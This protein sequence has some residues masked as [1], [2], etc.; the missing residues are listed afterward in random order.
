MRK[1]RWP[2]LLSLALLCCLGVEAA[3][4]A[5]PAAAT[6]KI[7]IYPEEGERVDQLRARGVGKVRDYGAFWLADVTPAQSAELKQQ[8]GKR[9]STCDYLDVIE[10][11]VCALNP[12]AG[13]PAI[14]PALQETLSV[15]KRL[16][17]LQLDG[18]VVPEWL[19]QIKAAGNVQI[20][21]YI[22]NNAYLVYVDQETEARLQLLRAPDGP[23]RWIGKYHPYY[24]VQPEL[25]NTQEAQ[26]S[27]RVQLVNDEDAAR[28]VEGLRRFNHGDDFRAGQGFNR[29]TAQL[30]VRPADLPAIARLPNVIWIE[31]VKAIE[32]KDEKQALILINKTNALASTPISTDRYIHFLTNTVGFSTDPNAYPIVDLADGLLSLFPSQVLPDFYELGNTNNPSRLPS[33]VKYGIT[34]PIGHGDQHA[35]QVA[36]IMSGYSLCSNIFTNR[37]IEQRTFTKT[38]LIDPFCNALDDPIIVDAPGD[39][40]LCSSTV[41]FPEIAERT[42]DVC[43]LVPEGLVVCNQFV[44]TNS[45]PDQCCFQVTLTWTYDF[46]VQ[47]NEVNQLGY[48]VRLGISPFGRF[49]NNAILGEFGESI[50]DAPDVLGLTVF[51]QAQFLARNQYLTSR[52]RIANNSWGVK[53]GDVNFDEAAGAYDELAQAYDAI[54]RDAILTGATNT[55]G[56]YPLNQEFICVFAAGNEQGL[57]DAGGFGD[58]LVFSPATAKNVISV[59]ASELPRQFPEDCGMFPTDSDNP[60]Q[61]AWFS[62]AGPTVDG[63]FKPD[64]VAP[65][66]SLLAPD[67]S[68][69]A[70][71]ANLLS[72]LCAGELQC[73]YGTSYAA[74][75]VS[76]AAQ[77]LWWYFQQRL[78]QFQPTPAMA[79]AYMCNSARHLKF[80]NPLTGTMDT[81]P[82]IGQ[83]MGILDLERMFDGFPRLIRDQTTP[84]AID[85]PLITTNPVSQQ[86]YFTRA[87]QSYEVSG[88]IFDA[89]RPFRVT[90]AWTDA[91]GDPAAFKQLQ[92][93]L[94]LD[95]RVNGQTYRGNVFAQE[96]S[97]PGGVFDDVNNI[98]SVHLPPGQTGTWS[99][100]VRAAVIAADG[101]PNVGSDI[102][103]DF[104]LVVYNAAANP[105]TTDTPIAGTNDTCSTA[106]PLTS[107]PY[108]FTGNVNKVIYRNNHPSPSAGRGGVDAFWK[109]PSPTP[110]TS[111]TV[112]TA[113]S[114]FDTLLSVWRVQIVPQ[115]VFVRGECGALVEQIST[116]NNSGTFQEE[117]T[118][119]ADGTNNYYIV[120]EPQNN[121]NGGQLIMNVEA[122]SPPIVV[123]P[124]LLD[125]G[126]VRIGATSD[127][128]QVTLQNNLTGGLDVSD[129]V[130]TGST[131]DFSIYTSNCNGTFLPSGGR[132]AVYVQFH[133]TSGGVRTADLRFFDNATGSP[134][135]VA[136]VGIGLPP[137]PDVCLAINGSLV[138]GNTQVG[139]SSAPQTVVITNCGTADLTITNVT[140]T[141]TASGDFDIVPNCNTPVAPGDTCSLD[142]TFTPATN[143]LRTAT[144]SLFSDAPNSPHQFVVSGTGFIPAPAICS[145]TL[146]DFPNT[147][148]GGSSLASVTITNCGTAPLVVTGLG[149]KG[150]QASEF[151]IAS[152]T[153]GVVATG[154]TCQ[155][156]LLFSPAAG[157]LRDAQLTITNNAAGS[158]HVVNLQ[159]NGVE[160]VPDGLIG[161]G[162]RIRV[163]RDGRL[164]SFLG[165]NIINI[166]A[167]NQTFPT[168]VK[169]GSPKGRKVYVTAKNAGTFAEPFRILGDAGGNGWS[170][171]Y[172]LGAQSDVDVTSQ[173]TNGTF[174]TSTMATNAVQGEA[175]MLRMEVFADL[176]VVSRT[177][178]TFFITYTSSI[179]PAKQDVVAA[180]VIAR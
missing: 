73:R 58:V 158:P 19:D 113:G 10:L 24:K 23:I 100:I 53:G 162:F 65:G 54:V 171:K 132:C 22:P 34:Y 144:V 26:L 122:T 147:T 76:G 17:L 85:Y 68:T 75:A 49:S 172:F 50:F 29:R 38:V 159:G 14:P 139:V 112:S 88:Q 93:D 177:T 15:G 89:T 111:F 137:A 63:R 140:K 131:S 155:V 64:L 128:Q 5:A 164:R 7:M 62:S 87:G 163:G 92:N 25:L 150:P 37:D 133:P 42:V 135:V 60:E 129:V 59:G 124:G 102:D 44:L 31:P 82:S 136:L 104:A 103:Q 72:V 119:V 30:Q 21:S 55:P 46:T 8:F 77:L 33:T 154:S 70:G 41:L 79:K 83:G 109:I 3:R 117:L 86:T 1:L 74:P 180:K 36:S 2:S 174:S 43:T 96:H 116:N 115:T 51:E 168:K 179:N 47:I 121:G 95:V 16:R 120:V 161:K 126:D 118:F 173:V 67:A 40:V 13:E 39:N 52:A 110:G 18:V 138:F 78:G 90:L 123:S 160:S 151:G 166:N 125:F 149:L 48:H 61:I 143:G 167:V 32:S 6:K 148:V 56:P 66:V 98:E 35:T 94:D 176:T 71:L 57:S 81:L 27:V 105:P 134:R 169:R 45:A 97:I 106:I 152:T 146:L 114:G 99:V 107:F 91:T 165:E 69:E 178:N 175:T 101:V 170:V 153:C 4:G 11:A 28:T 108:S 142:I 20:L 157:G 130:I 80:I 84:R 127:V 156:Q 141:G 9:L 12:Q 145:S